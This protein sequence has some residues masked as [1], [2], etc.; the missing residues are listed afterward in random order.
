LQYFNLKYIF[1]TSGANTDVV[2]KEIKK[3]LKKIKKKINK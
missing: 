1:T 2:D 3:K